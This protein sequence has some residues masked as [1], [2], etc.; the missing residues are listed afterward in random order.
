[1]IRLSCRPSSG[2][3]KTKLLEMLV[4]AQPWGAMVFALAAS[5]E[6]G[7]HAQTAVMAE[8]TKR[9]AGI[10][11]I[12]IAAPSFQVGVQVLY[13]GG[14]GLVA[15]ARPRHLTDY[16]ASLPQRFLRGLQVPVVAPTALKALFAAEGKSEKVQRFTSVEAN[17]GGFLSV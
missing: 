9:F 16:R 8:D 14:R 17:D 13:H 6:M 4:M 3:V 7:D 11:I 2:A 5:V 1:S 12:E 15:H 10:A